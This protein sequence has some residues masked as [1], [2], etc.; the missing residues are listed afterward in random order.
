[1][2][3]QDFDVSLNRVPLVPLVPLCQAYSDAVQDVYQSPGESG[4]SKV[5]QGVSR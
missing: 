1:M 5:G 4:A 3:L 2:E